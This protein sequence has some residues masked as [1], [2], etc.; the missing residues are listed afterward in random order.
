[1]DARATGRAGLRRGRGRGMRRRGQILVIALL[2]MTVLVG[3]VFYV[4]NLGHQVNRRMDL[5]NTA[6]AAGISAGAWMARSLNIIAMNNVAQSRLLSMVPLYDALPL[7][8]DMAFTEVDDWIGDEKYVQRGKVIGLQAQ[9]DRLAALMGN[10]PPG[11]S[12]MTLERI[13]D[14][15][16]G[17]RNRLDGAR[18]II[19]PVY[20]AMNPDSDPDWM[21]RTTVWSVPGVGGSPPHGKC[22]LGAVT[23][24][25][26]SDAVKESA[27]LLSVANAVRFGRRN[28]ARATVLVPIYPRMPAVKGGLGHFAYPLQHSLKVNLV[29]GGAEM[30]TAKDIGG[31]IPDWAWPHRLGPWARLLH[32][33]RA[34]H[35]WFYHHH[36]EP[37]RGWRKSWGERVQTGP[38]VTSTHVR[39]PHGGRRIVGPTVGGGR[40]GHGAGRGH[41]WQRGGTY[42]TSH[43]PTEF[44]P[45]GYTTY[46]PYHWGRDA[47]ILNYARYWHEDFG[48]A[49]NDSRFNEYYKT[50]ADTKL[51]YM[52]AGYSPGL[53]TIHVPNW[54]TDFDR[55]RQ[56]GDNPE[57]LKTRTKYY[58]VEIISKVPETDPG[59]L[60]TTTITSHNLGDPI[61]QETD[62]WLPPEKLPVPKS[63]PEFPVTPLQQVGNLAIWR[64]MGKGIERIYSPEG[65]LIDEWPVYFVWYWIFGGLD[66][67]GST[68]IRNPCNWDSSDELPAPLLLNTTEGDY[69]D[70]HDAGLRRE[71][72]TFL[73]V[74]RHNTAVPFWRRRY[75]TAN[76]MGS[77]LAMSQVEIFNHTSFGLWT[78]DWQAQL[79]PVTKWSDWV[80]KLKTGEGDVPLTEGWV[81]LDDVQHVHTFLSRLDPRIA[82]MHKNN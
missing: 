21:A 46:G 13:R 58:V 53:K 32:R 14:G 59:W 75:H 26:I 61:D 78:Q 6:D 55:A 29:D 43:T 28:T 40:T 73:A 67:G 20:K 52:F 44:N 42:T 76:P 81:G 51:E 9:I 27:G 17:V 7:A 41:G 47:W 8:T 57:V 60:S 16:I 12:S 45:K 2:G 33:P 74:A 71:K 68:Q 1:M 50:L 15:L 39:P 56:L 62:G 65:E 24:R 54:I 63:T 82:E 77:V 69:T 23:L 48:H 10:P 3:L 79:V 70:D 25:E 18:T 22:F 31:A 49:I 11:V 66:V 64:A 5:Q 72:F 4:Y 19:A 34:F 35:W 80:D 37:P 36:G 30:V 38:T